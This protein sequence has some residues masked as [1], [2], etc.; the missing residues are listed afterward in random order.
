[1]HFFKLSF[2]QLQ[3]WFL[4]SC[5]FLVKINLLHLAL[6][7]SA[8]YHFSSYRYDSCFPVCLF[9]LNQSFAFGIMHL[10]KLSF[11]QQLSIWFLFSCVSFQSKSIFCI[12][13]YAFLQVV[14]SS[15]AVDMILVFLC[16]VLVKINLLHLALCISSS[17][18][19]FS[20]CRYD[21]CFPM[22]RFS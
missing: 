14:I 13:H 10:F 16:V 20:S 5:V 7:I 12:W 22:C 8:S 11:L 17:C 3:I 15:A 18:H 2:L 6:C 9:S 1:M 19:F 21:S 4:F